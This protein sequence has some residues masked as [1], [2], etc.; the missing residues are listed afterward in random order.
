MSLHEMTL[1]P[2]DK[3]DP[4]WEENFLQ[5]LGSSSLKV[6]A[7]EPQSGPDGWPYLLT[8]TGEG[9][10]EPAAKILNWLATRG[11]GLVVNPTKSYP[12]YVISYGM[13]WSFKETG[14]FQRPA[15]QIPTGLVEIKEG[16]KLLAGPPSPEYLPAYVRNI[17]REFFRDQGLLAVKILVFSEDKK[18]FDLAFSLESLGQPPEKEHQGLLEA[19]GWFLPPHYSLVLISEKDLP[20]FELL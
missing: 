9:A 2:D 20:A 3:R 4:H 6:L 16:S 7:P 13:I 11:I 5:T 19:L 1:V 15:G 14:F 10:E 18:H 8:A 17:L 12:D